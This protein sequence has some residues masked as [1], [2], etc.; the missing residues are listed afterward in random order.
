MHAPAKYVD[1]FP[2]LSPDRRIMAAMLAAL[3]DGVGEVV[4]TLRRVDRFEDTFVF[5]QS[6]NGPS[7]EIANW[8]DG[9]TDPYYG[10]GCTLKGHKF[11][12]YEGGI[13]SPALACWPTRIP[14]GQ[15]IAEVGIAMDMF[16]TVV[17]AAGGDPRAYELDGREVLAMLADRAASPHDDIFWEMGRQTAVRRGRWKLVL[18]GQLVEGAPPDDDVFLAD[19][20]SDPGERVNLREK[21][22]ELV[23]ELREAGTSWRQSIE[24]RWEKEWR[25]LL[26]EVGTTSWR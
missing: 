18:H 19:L 25:P 4:E 15:T 10:G 13:R 6:D 23:A 1:R 11:S 16:P 9:R 22:P 12:L 26:A 8:L 24:D 17:R 14:A 21:Q 20:E 3:D 5:F 7:R 2:G